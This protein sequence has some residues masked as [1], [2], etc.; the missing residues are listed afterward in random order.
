V[1]RITTKN[2]KN[3]ACMRNNKDTHREPQIMV[4]EHNTTSN[5]LDRGQNTYH[6]L[7]CVKLYSPS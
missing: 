2:I 7:K 6:R 1:H 3:A 5:G 4:S